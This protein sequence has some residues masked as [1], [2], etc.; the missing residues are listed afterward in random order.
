MNNGYELRNYSV[1]A[2]IERRTEPPAK[3]ESL[4]VI[5]RFDGAFD[6]LQARRWILASLESYCT[7]VNSVRDSV[8]IFYTIVYN[9]ETLADKESI[10]SGT[11]SSRSGD[12]PIEDGFGGICCAS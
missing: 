3:F 6:A 4:H 2:E 12:L 11:G 8:K 9:G 1:E 5:Y 7:T 10:L